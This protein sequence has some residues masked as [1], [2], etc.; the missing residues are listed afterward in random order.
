[1]AIKNP[2]QFTSRTFNTILNDINS[3]SEL[4]DKPNWF[5]RIWAGIGDVV[6]MWI[7]AMGNN[8]VLRTSYTRQNTVDLL[9]L[10]DYFLSPQDTANGDILFYID[11][12]VSF[13]FSILEANLK[14]QTAGS[15]NVSSKIFEARS[16]LTV[17]E[18][19][20]GFLPGAVNISTDII[21]V[22]RTFTTGE[23]IILSGSDLPDPLVAGTEYWV[24]KV[25]DTTIRIA[26]SLSNA[27]AGIYID[28]TDQGT[29]T[30]NL[31]LY[32]VLVTVYQQE[33][34]D[35][36]SIG[37]SDGNTEWQ[38]FSLV[39]Q[40]ILKDTLIININGDIYEKVDTLVFSG[41]TDKHYEL[42]YTTDNVG[43]V[44]FGNGEYGIIPPAFDINSIFAIGGGS[45]S[46][47]NAVDNINIYAGSDN[48][49][50]G[51]SNF[52]TLSGGDDPESVDTGKRLGPL[53]LKAR[54]RFI[55]GEDGKALAENF[56]G[57]S[58]IRVNEN[59]FGI[60]SSQIIGIANGGGNA[61]TQLKSDLES[62]LISRT[63][64]ESIDVR[65][66][67]ATFLTQNVTSAIKLLPGYTFANVE[68]FTILAWQLFFSETG[69]EI[70]ENF[71]ANG[72]TST[73]SLIN[74]IFGTSFSTG[75]FDQIQTL[76]E[77]LE[78]RLIGVDIQ[79]S[80]AFGY[81]DTYVYG[82]DYITIS[83]PTF[84]ILVDIDEI[85][86]DGTMTITE[87]I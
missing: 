26:T 15:L 19:S 52:S 51:V 80:D 28:L 31:V 57:F 35:E 36:R 41:P 78:P 69:K 74:T 73:V 46:N 23:K 50:V 6:S 22:V 24:I 48:N 27:Y 5:K 4:A 8:L 43:L 37:Q 77:N 42:I 13:P 16:G 3:D 54:E 9:E 81:I 29:G 10:I 30:H 20:E 64:L 62:Y 32:S 67:D 12:G 47:I 33:T 84:P 1:M 82:V 39:E 25:S 71:E 86:T 34:Q 45:N 58:Q 65:V 17:N 68:P 38:N 66:Q 56:G 60:L 21:T 63:I 87:I 44:R 7:N 53:L 14:A 85:T 11:S 70:V 79:E 61:S 83:A 2:I 55:T 49:I 59:A 72:I 18:I 40:N 75:D 76:V